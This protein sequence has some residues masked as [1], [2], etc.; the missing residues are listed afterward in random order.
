MMRDEEHRHALGD[1]AAERLEQLAAFLRRQ[2]RRR[3]V[4]DDDARAAHQHLQDFDALLDADREQP[5]ALGRI[6]LQ[7]ELLRDSAAVCSIWA[8]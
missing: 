8:A 6:D 4:E 2:H 7:P 5:D 3:L 1:E